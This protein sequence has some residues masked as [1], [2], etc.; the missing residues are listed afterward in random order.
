MN[1]HNCAYVYEF[2]YV[3]TFYGL[4]MC[5]QICTPYQWRKRNKNVH[6]CIVLYM[7]VH[8]YACMYMHANKRIYL[9]K[10]RD[11]VCTYM[12]THTFVCEYAYT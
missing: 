3:H 1:V 4:S 12:H 6:F 2:P 11:N 8:I 9:L 5:V 10:N 7:Y